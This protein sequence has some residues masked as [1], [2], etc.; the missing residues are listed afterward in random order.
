MI[1]FV[2][3]KQ[4]TPV[5]FKLF[6]T[7]VEKNYDTTLN[8]WNGTIKNEDVLL[9]LDYNLIYL[10]V[11]IEFT[12][13]DEWEF[14]YNINYLPIEK[15][16]EKRR[17]IHFEHVSSYKEYGSSYTGAWRTRTEATNQAIKKGFDSLEDKQNKN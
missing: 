1:D 6:E 9:W 17:A 11:D 5:S 12:G 4:K 2:E 3:Q 14:A 8:I 13:T 16:D 10:C 15:E 7:W